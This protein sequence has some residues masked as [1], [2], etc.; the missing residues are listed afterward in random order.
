VS[1]DR[2]TNSDGRKVGRR[3]GSSVGSYVGS[4]VG[5][6]VGSNDGEGVGTLV[7]FSVGN[8][9]GYSVGFRVGSSVGSGVGTGVGPTVGVSVGAGEGTGVVGTGEGAKVGSNVGVGVGHLS[10][11]HAS[12]C[13]DCGQGAPSPTPGSTIVRVRDRRPP[14]QLTLHGCHATHSLNTQSFGLTPATTTHVPALHVSTTSVPGHGFAAGAERG[15]RIVRRIVRVP[16][17]QRTLQ[18]VQPVQKPTRQSAD[19]QNGCGS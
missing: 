6:S 19:L 17:P 18:L 16:K 15:V 3:V 4:R 8:S 12:I 5:R 9:D 11:A 2:S 7:G 1:V 13:S 10:S 14:P